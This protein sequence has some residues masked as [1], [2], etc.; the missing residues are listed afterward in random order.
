LVGRIFPALLSLLIA[1]CTVPTAAS[2]E[3]LDDP[4]DLASARTTALGGPHAAATGGMTTLF[5]NPAGFAQAEPE[6]A[7]TELSVGLSG[8]VFTITGLVV[9]GVSGD[10]SA[11]LASDQI[12]DVLSGLYASLN[13]VG[14]LYF[15]YVGN[16]LG[17]GIF[18]TS[19]VVFRSPR[20]LSLEATARESVLLCG[21]YAL[22]VPFPDSWGASM[23]IGF[24]LKGFLR[25]ETSVSTSILEL[26]SLIAS[27]GPDT[28]MN[29][30][31]LLTTGIGVDAG[32]RVG[33]RDIIAV[34]VVGRDLYSPTL[35][36]SYATV[37]GFLDNTE[38]PT[39]TNARVPIDLSAGLLFT[40][41][42]GVF[43][44]FV[45][46][47]TIMLDYNDI[48]DFLTHP[49]TARN[50]VLHPGLGVELTLLE[51]L[52]LRGG[53]SQG[54]FSAGLGMDLTYFNLNASMYGTELSPEPGLRPVYNVL[55]GFE[56]RI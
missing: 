35:R 42:L 19:D 5:Y 1:L 48:L 2:A 3:A 47:L 54:L 4:V 51:I 31:F 13:L 30:P 40:P 37:S 10:V 22:R 39:Q 53:F 24:L 18:N 32:I 33:Y 45:S 15:G 21:G 52:H 12:Q 36:N 29:E 34:G 28:V 14:P 27:I 6:M 41:G 44:R 55:I 46:E 8:P 16:G 25:G 9:Q 20:S 7:V 56:F 26:E 38:S 17:F 50:P 11:I 43:E 49:A 23:D